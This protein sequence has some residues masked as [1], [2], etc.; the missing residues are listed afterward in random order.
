MFLCKQVTLCVILNGRQIQIQTKIRVWCCLATQTYKYQK[1]NNFCYF[2]QRPPNSNK[3]NIDVF[4][5][6]HTDAYKGEVLELTYMTY[7]LHGCAFT[8]IHTYIQTFI[9]YI[10]TYFTP[11]NT[12]IHRIHV[13][14]H[15]YIT[16]KTTYVHILSTYIHANLSIYTLHLDITYAHTYINTYI[17]TYIRTYLLT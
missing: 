9:T 11:V 10:H 4:F 2:L 15:T 3:Q 1:Q 7:T 16:Y 6:L 12:Y 8:C 17:H 5:L 13:Q 14:L